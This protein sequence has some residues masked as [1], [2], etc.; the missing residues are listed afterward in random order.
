M[1]IGGVDARDFPKNKSVPFLLK[2][3]TISSNGL[4]P[5]IVKFC[6]IQHV[7]VCEVLKIVTQSVFLADTYRVILSRY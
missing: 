6:L 7:R 3:P 1:R 4:L 5:N 2:T